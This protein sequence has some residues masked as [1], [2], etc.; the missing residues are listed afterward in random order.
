M[1]IVNIMGGL[2]NQMFEYAFAISLREKFPDEDVLI[3][4]SH[5]GHIFFK[6]YKGANLHNGFEIDRVFPNADINKARPFQLMRMTWYM[7][8]YVISRVLRRVLPKR[9][10]EIIQHKKDFFAY[11]ESYYRSGDFY[12]EGIWESVHFYIPIR[13]ML[14]K[15]F[16]HGIPNETNSKYIEEMEICNSVGIHIRRGDYLQCPEF[17]GITD[18]D[19][20]KRGINEILAD[21]LQ[22]SFFIFSNDT[23]W[24]KDNIEPLVK[25]HRVVFVTENTGKQSCWDMF[26]M[27][28]CKDLIIANSSFS[29]WGAFLNDRGGRV[30]A[31]KK[32]VNRNAEV[33]I[34]LEGW[35]RI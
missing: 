1:K 17:M 15:T 9:K 16:T 22:H 5:Y 19:Y 3:D 12:Y 23:I 11:D 24:C 26:L 13:Q 20:Y 35:I 8:N 31:P 25:G 14:R 27:T 32:W 6:R 34:W 28:H 4:T 30:V 21:G 7:P 10:T 2:G 33:D 29:W 18:L